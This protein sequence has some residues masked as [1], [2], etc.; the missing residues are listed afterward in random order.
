MRYLFILLLLF[1]N[2]YVFAGVNIKNG[3]FFVSYTDQEFSATGGYD[4]M[5]TYNS[6]SVEIGL[7]GFGWGTRIDTKIFLIG[8]GNILIKEHGSGASSFYLPVN[9]SQNLVND[10]IEKIVKAMIKAG[11][12]EASPTAIA[13]LKAEL[14]DTEMRARKWLKYNL[15]NS[16]RSTFK[17]SGAYYL[18][19][20]STDKIFYQNNQFSRRLYNGDIET[21][22]INGNLISNTKSNGRK[23]FTITYENNRIKTLT[24]AVNNILQFETNIA[25]RIIS[26]SSSKGKSVYEYDKEN[27]L[28]KSIDIENNTYWHSYDKSKNMIQIKYIDNTT[29]DIKYDPITYFAISIKDRENNITKYKYIN[30]YTPSG[31]IDDDHYATLVVKQNSKNKIDSSYY[32]Y[33]IKQ[34]SA[35]MRYTQKYIYVNNGVKNEILNDESGYTI[36]A[37]RSKRYAIFK[38]NKE[39]KIAIKETENF[40]YKPTYDKNSNLIALEKFYKKLKKTDVSTYKYNELDSLLALKINKDWVKIKRDSNLKV[41]GYE[42]SL[43]N[44]NLAYNESDKVKAITNNKL[45]TLAILYNKDGKVVTNPKNSIYILYRKILSYC[46]IRDLEYWFED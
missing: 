44:I 23:T 34:N 39:R 26:I 5:R 35:G 29:F 20:G 21:F 7:F 2:I 41:I 8:D 17:F 46:T 13:K 42:S 31:E 19:D 11:D 1:F 3:N 18:S 40:I 12:L 4:I 24:D 33:V 30:F 43:G 28:V 10:C 38:R 14:N 37:T 32:E 16:N 25:G 22:D 6:K 9:K 27:C 45:G 15:K 36:K